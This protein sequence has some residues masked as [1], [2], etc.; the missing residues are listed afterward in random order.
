MRHADFKTDLQRLQQLHI[1]GTCQWLLQSPSYLKWRDVS[2]KLN[3]SDFLWIQG[4]PGCGKS[5]LASQII[6]DLHS[7]GGSVVL[8]IFCKNGDEN[9]NTLESVLRNLIFEILEFSPQQA[10][11]RLLLNTRLNEKS[12]YAQSEETLWN[13][14]TQMIKEVNFIHCVIDG[15]DECQSS[16][17]ER[18]SFL[19]RLVEIFKQTPHAKLILISQLHLS[20]SAEHFSLWIDITIQPSNV[21][22]DI[23]LLALTRM[24]ESKK[25]CAH[26]Q[27]DSLLEQLVARSNGMI[28]WA[29]LMIK[30]LELG[31]WNIQ[32]V[33]Q[34]PPEGLFEMWQS[35][36]QRISNS[37]LITK[38]ISDALQLV[39][40]AAQPLSLEELALGLAVAHG[41]C[42]HEDYDTREDAMIE[43][44]LIVQESSPLLI[45]MPDNTVQLTHTS[46]RE[47]LF[48]Q[49]LPSVPKFFGFNEQ[50]AHVRMS[51]VLITYMSF[52]IFQ[53]ALT[54][55]LQPKCFLLEY[56]TRWLV[57]HTTRTGISTQV[58]KRLLAFFDIIQGWKW[59]QRLSDAYDVSFGHLQLLQLEL[60]TWAQ[61]SCFDDKTVNTFSNVL[62]ILAQKR[63]EAMKSLPNDD[64]LLL[65]SME[66]MALTFSHQKKWKKAEEMHLKVLEIY[67]RV[68]GAEHPNTLKTFSNLAMVYNGQGRYDESEKLFMQI[69]ETSPMVLGAESLD[70]MHNLAMT[71]DNQGRYKE[72][73]SLGL[74]ILAIRSRTLG[75]EHP[76]TLMSMHNLA[77]TF[78][79]QKR[80]N[81][82]EKLYVQVLETRTKVLGS[83]H[84]DTLMSMQNLAYTFTHQQRLK[85][86]EHIQVRAAGIE[87]KLLGAEHS[88]TLT[89]MRNLAWTY[90]KQGR[91]KESEELG[92]EILEKSKRVLG[93]EHPLT[94][95]SMHNLAAT[96]RGQKRL[97]EAEEIQLQVLEIQNRVL[98]PE[99]PETMCSTHNLA[100]IYDGQG[101]YQESEKL[102]KQIMKTRTKLLGAEHPDT[103]LSM[104]NL[105]QVIFNQDRVKEA[106]EIQVQVL[107]TQ[108]R[109][110]GAE[111]P[112]TLL[113]MQNLA[114]IF[115][116][117][118][119]YEESENLY[120]QVIETSKRALGPEHPQILASMQNLAGIIARQKRFKEAEELLVQV[121]EM[122]TKVLGVEHPDT[123]MSMQ[124]LASLFGSQDRLREA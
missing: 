20:E 61:S 18:V 119:R 14:I 73:E 35:I 76:N 115:T 25:L 62:L 105:A 55:Q 107:E 106:E 69:L 70:V 60:A 84:P 85:E 54:T 42:D 117:Q 39:L 6:R 95:C 65:K 52:Q 10:F 112:T 40:A 27:K 96:F 31:H 32:S 109:V 26:P 113:Y 43:G 5:V 110:S 104:H 50:D 97:K 49:E 21:R 37:R 64:R 13:I 81:E 78:A 77:A 82:A 72:S 101:R 4:K 71:F 38:K 33:L 7:L 47:Y 93:E 30:E 15:L 58:S 80:F 45:S 116:S 17:P 123:L 83:E 108:K 46:L 79:L 36:L 2:S 56:A 53:A 120:M 57:Y 28:L 9:K 23:G 124:S 66:N 16:T 59:L 29:E 75:S 34:R 24:E 92:E 114:G 1:S 94:L 99:H 44:R 19:S 68:L 41:L 86:A 118:G 63:Y 22:D 51:I 90:H 87:K 74:Q 103:L 102:N 88:N 91:Y 111:D 100:G 89:S 121:L 122:R 67:E 48:S 11:H 8:Y 12:Q 3:A 98:G